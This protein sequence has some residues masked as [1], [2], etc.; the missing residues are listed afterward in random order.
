[1]SIYEGK[2]KQREK[3]LADHTGPLTY[4]ELTLYQTTEL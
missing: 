3:K 2:D 4:R 1:M